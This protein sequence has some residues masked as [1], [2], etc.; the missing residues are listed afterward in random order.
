MES[1]NP[2]VSLP[3]DPGLGS[4]RSSISVPPS[5]PSFPRRPSGRIVVTNGSSAENTPPP[6]SRVRTI[7]EG[8]PED[9]SGALDTPIKERRSSLWDDTSNPGLPRP[10]RPRATIGGGGS[11]G[12]P[13]NLT[14]REQ[15]KLIDEVRK[16]NFDLKLKV[17]FLEERLT[18]LAPEHMVAASQ[19]NIKLKVEVHSRGQEIKK[20][21]K[22]VLELEK[23]LLAVQQDKEQDRKK[24][25]DDDA[26]RDEY[27]AQLE[28]KDH[29][30]QELKNKVKALEARPPPTP[31]STSSTAAYAQLRDDYDNLMAR[32][33][34]LEDEL[35]T[36]KT[37][38]QE[39]TEE[40]QTIES[41]YD[42][43]RNA[44]ESSSERQK[45]E[46]LHGTIEAMDRQLQLLEDERDSLADDLAR[47]HA[48]FNESERRRQLDIADRSASRAEALE[49]R[50]EKES[51]ERNNN[52]IRDKLA[53][54]KIELSQRELELETSMRQ[55]EEQ[56]DIEEQWRETCEKLED[57][58]DRLKQ[59]VTR[60]EE[61]AADLETRCES[62]ESERR[63]LSE[64]VEAAVRH[65]NV[66]IAEREDEIARLDE[67]LR[68]RDHVLHERQEDLAD[69]N[70][71]IARLSGM[72][73][74][75]EDQLDYIK[76]EM[77]REKADHDDMGRV[78]EALKEKISKYKTQLSEVSN[79]YEDLRQQYIEA[80]E[81]MT[82]LEKQFQELKD[83]YHDEC[84]ARVNAER[85]IRNYDDRMDE[86][87]GEVRKRKLDVEDVENRWKR[88]REDMEA[89]HQ[90]AIKDIRDLLLQRES[91][92][93]SLQQALNDVESKSRQLGESHTTDRFALEMEL[94]RCRRD[95]LRTEQE[96]ERVRK[97]A[98]EREEKAR[99]R[100]GVLDRLHAEN[101]DLASQLAAQTQ[102][103]L[104]LSEKL[105]SA[106]AAQKATETELNTL[107][108][109]TSE[110][111][112][113]LSKDQKQL[114]T[115]ETQY[116]E[117]LTERNTLLLTV[118]QYLDKIIGADKSLKKTGGA[119]TKPYTNF[120]VFHDSLIAKFKIVSQIQ[121]EFDKRCKAIE[122]RFTEK[123]NDL[124]KQLD[125][126]WKQIDRFEASTKAAVEK[127]T[128][129][130]R[131]LQ[132]KEGELE[133]LRAANAE[134]SA[135]LS[136]LKRTSSSPTELS[137]LKGMT[138][139]LADAERRVNRANNLNISKDETISA[140]Q[141][142]QV[143]ADSRWEARVAE[144]ERMIKALEE[145]LKRERQGS[146]ES[147]AALQK[148]L[149]NV[150][151][152][153]ARI[154]RVDS[155]L[156]AAIE[157]RASG[158]GDQKRSG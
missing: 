66:Q 67:D 16:E 102:A 111:E 155:G 5:I 138:A 45:I 69:A 154:Q 28:E 27:E 112:H 15:E 77:R 150:K 79:K 12:G 59:V 126:K 143:T 147:I 74:D 114:S 18:Q 50:E 14:L 135:Q 35:L 13:T 1:S 61:N 145:K 54:A 57:E 63:D 139:K 64:K 110:L 25:G 137:K 121:L 142:R 41:E 123:L 108:N 97:D 119:E 37:A 87:E 48:E 60:M 51:L 117:Q 71:E 151:E 158:S 100:E 96:L 125:H 78:N 104:N 86:L 10:K 55:I 44:V 88:D 11:K 95:L 31:K 24:V 122:A 36:A 141:E 124:K 81:Q 115:T 136:A 94:E 116:R 65:M 26:M 75:L 107:R 73:R 43:Y 4:L 113:R 9:P 156:D 89:G 132:A 19:M 30:I 42:Q 53:L 131:K 17:H 7:L 2:D 140:L 98:K 146:K 52:E 133:S 34:E 3:E 84:E 21:K 134:A 23:E 130:R 46:E 93:A 76:E 72:C 68:D 62:L 40:I 105:D 91:D 20:L 56:N 90:A 39:S 49:E 6:S 127:H 101:R 85:T 58:N 152:H 22:L 148:E 128:S 32:Q 33:S 92:I 29:E 99:E 82:A 103:R 153:R 144:Y 70:D 149:E 38:L 8:D 157:R 129:I 120:S 80:D 83:D 109:R 106:Q 118:Y 47:L